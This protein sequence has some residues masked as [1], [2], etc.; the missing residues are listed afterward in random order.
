MTDY[1]FTSPQGTQY[2]V[3]GPD[4]SDPQE[5][6]MRLQRKLSGMPDLP[7]KMSWGDVGTQ[8][9]K[10]IPSSAVGFAKDVAQPFIH[11]V[12][13]AKS[14]YNLGAGILEKSGI[15]SGDEH[16][17]YADAVGQ[18]FVDR[19]GGVENVKRTLATDPVGL[20]ADLS[21]AF[22]AG[23][24]LAA[25]APGLVGRLGEVA[26]TV[27][28]TI[29]PL[30]VA[31]RGAAKT[32]NLATT[33]GTGGARASG[34][35][36]RDIL[37]ALQRDKM[38]PQ[39]ATSAGA[40]VARDRP[41]M[42]TLA[43]VGG[44]NVKGLLERVAQTPGGGRSEVIPKLVARQQ[45]QLTRL[46]N[47]L[48]G[49]TGTTKTAVQ[50]VRDSVD[51]Q[52]KAATP[53]YTKAY[54]AG[55][56]VIWDKEIERLTGARD[57]RDAMHAAVASWERNAIADGY[58]AMNPRAMVENQMI[59]FQKGGI[60]AF[61]NLQFWDYTKH[62]LDA[63]ISAE[64]DAKTGRL[65]K[66]GRDLNIIKNKLVG[67]LDREVPEY[68]TARQ[69]YAG[70]S[71]YMNAIGEG[72]DLLNRTLTAEE[73]R[74]MMADFSDAE[75]QGYR[76][77]VVSSIV[78]KM[79]A[80]P[81]KLADY[82]KYL[83]SP[84]M[85]DKIAAIMPTPELAEKWK[86]RLDLEDRSSEMVGRALKGSPTARR[87]AEVQDASVVGDLVMDA[88]K[89]GGRPSSLALKAATAIPKYIRDRMRMKAD[90]RIARLLT[91]PGALQHLDMTLK[92]GMARREPL[93]RPG[94]Q[95]IG[96]RAHPAT[97]AAFQTGRLSQLQ[98]DA[99]EALKDKE[100]YFTKAQKES[101]RAVARGTGSIDQRMQVN[102]LLKGNREDIPQI[103]VHPRPYGGPQ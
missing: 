41:N 103:T 50:A 93:F 76:T 25:R 26:G 38:T 34:A 84:E 37:R 62:A 22:T 27:G 11:P 23:G 68:A 40:A 65:T 69:K 100:R 90:E 71:Q 73:V 51:E 89:S 35:A 64:V 13:T 14:F 19:Y 44:E 77:G 10:N 63:M 75:R 67:V 98:D 72:K 17:K 31:V 96:Y 5:A 78:T 85:R 88:I 102:D 94:A 47:D 43:D 24:G 95:R 80:D 61:P 45:E 82:T 49:L 28:R 53:L 29:D 56:R 18:F 101:L 97:A 1:L 36:D 32:A 6:L 83:R 54:D 42:Q 9:I 74:H 21:T 60:P 8:A 66:K 7:D 2:R 91:S 79:R 46:G 86:R 57:V 58:G 4:G 55:D 12:D 48:K 39:D 87:L 3:S 15:K 81:S 33:L 52:R 99:K 30:N 92:G 20:L 70:E 16:K 59:K